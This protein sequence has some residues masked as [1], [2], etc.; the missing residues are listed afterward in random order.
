MKRLSGKSIGLVG[1]C[2]MALLALIPLRAHASE[3]TLAKI[4]V[5]NP[6]SGWSVLQDSTVYGQGDGLTNIYDGGYQAYTGAGVLEALRRIYV[7]GDTYIEA[8][9]HGMQS[10][11]SAKTFLADRYRTETGKD[12]PRTADWDSF[13][14]SIAGTTTVYA[15]QGSYFV[16]VLAYSEG[17][18]AEEFTTAIMKSLLENAVKLG[19]GGK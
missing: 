12:A 1:V 2:A 9:V 11:R 16:T 3:A 13:T 5:D 8:T 18:N 4:A 10:A 15:V 7:K 19:P 14:V 17:E 6:V